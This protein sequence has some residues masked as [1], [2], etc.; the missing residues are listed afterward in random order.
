MDLEIDKKK[1]FKNKIVNFYFNNKSKIYILLFIFLI[2]IISL[3][4]FKKNLSE[5]NNL[6]SEKYMQAGIYMQK[7]DNKNAIIL[8]NDVILSKNKFYSVLALNTILEKNLVT[9]KKKILN[10][11]EII[12]KLKIAEDKKDLILLKKALYL[13]KISDKKDGQD[14]LKKIIEKNSKL[15]SIAEILIE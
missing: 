9:E 10:Y 14:I 15:K 6:V 11:F 7:N 13:I 5:K 3:F 2:S 4:L 8:L 1:E 12:E